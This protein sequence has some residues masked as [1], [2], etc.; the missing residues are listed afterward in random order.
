MENQTAAPERAKPRK[1]KRLGYII[2]III[3]AAL[4]VVANSILDWDILPFLMPD[5]TRVLLLLN[6]SLTATIVANV[7]FLL[8]DPDWF[9]ALCR[10]VL[11]AVGIAVSV[12]FLTVFPFDFSAYTGFDWA[13]LARV[14]IILGIAGSSIGVIVE[15][16]KLVRALAKR[17]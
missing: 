15:A 11:N 2:A 8:F 9:T 3:N 6:I 5:F 16:V 13:L 1:G 17:T 7:A 4:L 10:M 14:L 12:S